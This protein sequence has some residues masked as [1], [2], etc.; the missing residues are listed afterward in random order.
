M[1]SL[2]I[3][4]RIMLITFHQQFDTGLSDWA[5][6]DVDCNIATEKNNDSPVK[7]QPHTR[8]YFGSFPFSSVFQ[9]KLIDLINCTAEKTR[10]ARFLSLVKGR[11]NCSFTSELCSSHEACYYFWFQIKS[12]NQRCDRFFNFS[13]RRVKFSNF[14]RPYPKLFLPVLFA[15]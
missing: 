7:L 15:R 3:Y 10:A 8:K 1:L 14:F 13:V 6:A 12:I 5:I 9:T 4:T 2:K 11:Y